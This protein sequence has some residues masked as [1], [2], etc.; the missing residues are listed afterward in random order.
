M[1]GPTPLRDIV[2]S[3]EG[4]LVVARLFY[5]VNARWIAFTE[6][7]RQEVSM[8]DLQQTSSVTRNA[9]EIPLIDPATFA[10]EEYKAIQMKINQHRDT[11]SRLETFTIG[12]TVAGVGFLLGIGR[13]RCDDFLFTRFAWWG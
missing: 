2:G 9:K 4:R 5:W 1:S 3:S 11:V 13:T 10:L 8:T 7:K 6:R 12:G